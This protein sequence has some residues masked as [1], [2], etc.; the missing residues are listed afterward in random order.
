MIRIIVGNVPHFLQSIQLQFPYAKH[1]QHQFSCRG[2]QDAM[3]T[4]GMAGIFV[5][6]LDRCHMIHV[7]S[8]F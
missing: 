8:I 1:L 5:K 6:L 7:I 4:Y 3:C 2:G